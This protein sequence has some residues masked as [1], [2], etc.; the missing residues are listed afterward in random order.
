MF[1]RE[2]EPLAII[3]IGPGLEFPWEPG[4]VSERR[5]DFYGNQKTDSPRLR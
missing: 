1:M 2:L 5:W 4:C 3:K